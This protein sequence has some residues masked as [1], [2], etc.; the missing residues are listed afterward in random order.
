MTR[1]SQP[2]RISCAGLAAV[3]PAPELGSLAVPGRHVVLQ[4]PPSFQEGKR[5]VVERLARQLP[6]HSVFDSGPGPEGTTCVTV[7]KV[8]DER[9]V[10]ENLPLFLAA[11]RDFSGTANDL[12]RRL[13]EAQGIRPE[14]LLD[15]R[16]EIEGGRLGDWDCDF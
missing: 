13:A 6:G 10:L 16:E 4:L 15:T 9:V 3:P 1:P 11:I 5:E 12:C 7:L 8:I 14:E 2:L